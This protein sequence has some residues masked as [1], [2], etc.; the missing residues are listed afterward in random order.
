VLAN[1]FSTRAYRKK[2]D[3]LD[4]ERIARQGLAGNVIVSHLP[5]TH[6]LYGFRQLCRSR[7]KL[8]MERARFAHRIKKVYDMCGLRVKSVREARR[9]LDELPFTY[10]VQAEVFLQAYDSLTEAMKKLEKAIVG[11]ARELFGELYDILQS[12]PGVGPLLAAVILAETVDFGRFR[13]ADHYKSYCGLAPR[14]RE[15]AGRARL[16]RCVKGNPYLR[17]A[18][19]M[20]AIRSMR[21]DKEL[22]AFYERLIERG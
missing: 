19:Y 3:E 18:F 20:A 16:G 21:S 1:P 14:L 2:T 22:R 9:R 17:W 8:A 5:D 13:S 11:E 4:A 12:V 15:S 6:R 10:G 7:V